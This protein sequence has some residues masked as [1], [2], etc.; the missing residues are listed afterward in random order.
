MTL[1]DLERRKRPLL[2]IEKSCSAHHKNF[3]EDRLMLSAAKCR[4]MDLFSTNIKYM[5][6]FV[7]VPLERSV[8]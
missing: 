2:E 8:M 3:D 4:P 5:Q 7:G 6:L 1:D